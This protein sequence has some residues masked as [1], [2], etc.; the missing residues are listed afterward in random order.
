MTT[1]AEL[2]AWAEDHAGEQDYHLILALLDVAEAA[3]KF[4]DEDLGHDTP[5][6]RELDAALA[7]LH[8]IGDQK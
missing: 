8:A 4:R 3:A 7:H 2:R 6:E 1:V 5:N